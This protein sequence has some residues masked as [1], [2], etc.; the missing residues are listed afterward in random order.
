MQ[1]VRVGVALRRAAVRAVRAPSVHNTQPWRVVL[2]PESLS[3][4]PDPSRR[5]ASFDPTG[6]QLLLSCGC[7]AANAQ[8]ALAAEGL[9]SSVHIGPLNEPW[10]VTEVAIDRAAPEPG[11]AAL[12]AVIDLR[13]TP[14][15]ALEVEA[16][17]RALLRRLRAAAAAVGVELGR[18]DTEPARLA[19][20]RMARLGSQVLCSYPDYLTELRA[21]TAGPARADGLPPAALDELAGLSRVQTDPEPAGAGEPCEIVWLATRYDDPI[22]WA[23]TGVVLERVLLELTKAGLAAVP[24]AQIVEVPTQRSAFAERAGALG[25]PQAILRVGRA[26]LALPTRRRLLVDVIA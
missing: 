11:L 18:I 1:D 8:I 26:P 13:G 24:L 3:V 2:G 15:V 25:R 22:A 20:D 19:V 9:A 4:V 23:G 10:P 7:A 17:P 14:R 5:V 6:R 12:D 16:V 21:W